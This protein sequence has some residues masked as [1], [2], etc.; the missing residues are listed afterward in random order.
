MKASSTPVVCRFAQDHLHDRTRTRP[1]SGSDPPTAWAV[2][3]GPVV[4][5]EA[6]FVR[7]LHLAFAANQQSEMVRSPRVGSPSAVLSLSLCNQFIH[8]V[9]APKRLR[10]AREAHVCVVIRTAVGIL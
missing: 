9:R 2:A 7:C 3:I 5:A 1:S 6:P 4:R 8:V 10:S